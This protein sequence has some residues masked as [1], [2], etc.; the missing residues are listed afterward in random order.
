MK[1]NTLFGWNIDK[2]KTKIEMVLKHLI[3]RGNIT[4]WEAITK[5]K[6]TRLS[7]IIHN[8][9]VRFEIETVTQRDT[10]DG[11]NSYAIYNYVG[12]KKV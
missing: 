7:A 5:Y 8:L 11:R 10:E 2:P 3:K 4:S 9:R 12:K 6:A 1:N